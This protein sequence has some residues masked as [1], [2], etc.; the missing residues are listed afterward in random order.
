[1]TRRFPPIINSSP[2][3]PDE[4]KRQHPATFA[5]CDVRKLVSFFSKKGDVVLDPF[6]GSG[7]TMLTCL[8]TGR[9]CIGIE[10][11]WKWVS[12]SRKRI[13]RASSNI[14]LCRVKAGREILLVAN[15]GLRFQ[16]LCG[17][18]RERLKELPSDSVDFIITSPPYWNILD[19]TGEYKVV[20]MRRK[21]DLP[22]N[23][24]TSKSN[25]GNIRDYCVFLEQLEV[26]F[27]QCIRVLRAGKYLCVV[28][29]DFRH[30]NKF[31]PFHA[32]L[33]SRLERCGAVLEG[34]TVI[35]SNRKYLYPYGMPY[36]YVSNI[37]HSYVLIFKNKKGPERTPIGA[38]SAICGNSGV[39][40][41]DVAIR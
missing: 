26:I 28:V 32:H 8:E 34:I 22:T 14:P 23:Y 5:E 33:V 17:D 40:S 35:V 6:L 4:L 30:R 13:E 37:H 39:S 18:S 9:N 25:L 3:S 31:Y 12:L 27:R 20:H 41:S 2:P 1:M 24:G 10:L 29:A 19:K 36:S 21:F 15:G 38:R 16:I 7:S 11:F